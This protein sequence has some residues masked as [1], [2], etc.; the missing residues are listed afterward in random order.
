MYF[1]FILLWTPIHIDD[2][3]HYATKKSDLT[4]RGFDIIAPG[5]WH[6]VYS[7]D[8]ETAIEVG[9]NFNYFYKTLDFHLDL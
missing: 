2:M 8:T 7:D 9:K 6:T 5:V 3:S 4:A 1:S